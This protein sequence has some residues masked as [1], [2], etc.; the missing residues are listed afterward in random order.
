MDW[1]QIG[2][3]IAMKQRKKRQKDKWYL[4]RAPIHTPCLYFQKK[5]DAPRPPARTSPPSPP[6]TK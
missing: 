4:F 5:A 2:P 6:A 3:K 1:P